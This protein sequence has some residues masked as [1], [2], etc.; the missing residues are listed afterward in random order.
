ME[1]RTRGLAVTAMLLALVVLAG[2]ADAGKN[3]KCRANGQVFEQGQ[4]ACILGKLARCE[5]FLNNSS[6]KTIA[7]V[8]PQ[9]GLPLVPQLF[10]RLPKAPLQSTLPSC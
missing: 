8:C 2:P 6:W 9:S 10:A 3:C 4:I 1:H 5:M 7:D